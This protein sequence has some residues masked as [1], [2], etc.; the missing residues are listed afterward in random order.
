MRPPSV[1]VREPSAQ[2]DERLP[3]D[4]VA[5]RRS[6]SEQEQARHRRADSSLRP[7]S[8]VPG[9]QEGARF[10][11]TGLRGTAASSC[12]GDLRGAAIWSLRLRPAELART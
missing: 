2:E 8:R 6:R 4:D 10:A 11:R 1:F 3:R 12:R 9:N 7:I 5:M